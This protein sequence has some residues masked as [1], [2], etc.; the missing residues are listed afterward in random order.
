MQ[1]KIL[2]D[3]TYAD[4]GVHHDVCKGDLCELPDFVAGVWLKDGRCELPGKKEKSPV[5][6]DKSI[7]PVDENK[8][9][10]KKKATKKKAK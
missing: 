1:V 7:N 6:E 5:V 3:A 10:P 4:C 2:K 9:A 8:A